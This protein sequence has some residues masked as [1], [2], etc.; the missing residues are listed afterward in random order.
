MQF[1]E[2]GSGVL[3]LHV[4]CAM[5]QEVARALY[6]GMKVARALLKWQYAIK[7]KKCGMCN[8]EC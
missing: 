3:D 7:K 6:N 5:F 4:Q 2:T 8:V 1:Y